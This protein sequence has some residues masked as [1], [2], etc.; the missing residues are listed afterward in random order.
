MKIS[1]KS[2][3]E[4]G[5][6]ESQ[7]QLGAFSELIGNL[8]GPTKLIANK[9]L[10]SSFA[11]DVKK[12]LNNCGIENASD[13]LKKLIDVAVQQSAD[14]IRLNIAI[15]SIIILSIVDILAIIGVHYIDGNIMIPIA[16]FAVLAVIIWSVTGKISKMI[17]KNVTGFK[18]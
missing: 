8:T 3:I 13:A 1:E 14:K 9:I 10:N 6:A 7:L 16:V 5:N 2:E 17:S 12:I 18:T 15:V 11:E 4:Q